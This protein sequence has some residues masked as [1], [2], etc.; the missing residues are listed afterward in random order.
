[1]GIAGRNL[2]ASQQTSRKRPSEAGE[3]GLDLQGGPDQRGRM[4]WAPL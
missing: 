3:R 2:R 1:M 4:I